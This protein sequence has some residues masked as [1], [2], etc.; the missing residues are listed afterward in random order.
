MI[1]KA[2]LVMKKLSKNFSKLLNLMQRLSF[3]K[4]DEVAEKFFSDVRG[5]ILSSNMIIYQVFL[6]T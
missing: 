1:L 3:K 4:A 2:I 5:K 6:K